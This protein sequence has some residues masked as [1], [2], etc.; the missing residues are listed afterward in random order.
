[1]DDPRLAPGAAPEALA[2]VGP[3]GMIAEQPVRVGARTLGGTEE[4]T[5]SRGMVY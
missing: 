5:G 3:M 4:G 2:V 1:M